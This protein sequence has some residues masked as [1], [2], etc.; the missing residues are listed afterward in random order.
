MR[1]GKGIS[2]FISGSHKTKAL[3]VQWDLATDELGVQADLVSV[4][5]VK[6]GLSAIASIYDPLGILAPVLFEGRINVQDLCRLKIDWD[7]E[8]DFNTTDHIRAWVNKLN[9]TRGISVPRCLKVIGW[10]SA[11]LVQLHLFS[12]ASIMALGVVVYLQVTDQWGNVSCRFIMGKARVAQLKNV[13][14]PCLELSA[15]VLAVKFGTT[16]LAMIDFKVDE[17]LLDRFN[18]CLAVYS[19]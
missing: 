6:S 17:V 7:M 9:Q 19:E 1:G 8:L 18:N 11:T 15:A 5:R 10:Q 16:I 14:V 13:S 3:G 12:D 4:P 2:G